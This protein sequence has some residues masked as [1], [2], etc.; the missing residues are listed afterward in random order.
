MAALFTRIFM[1]ERLPSDIIH[2]GRHLITALRNLDI[3]GMF[4]SGAVAR[5]IPARVSIEAA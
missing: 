2:K 3:Q 5:Y 1:P 4:I